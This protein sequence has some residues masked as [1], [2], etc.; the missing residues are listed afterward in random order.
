MHGARHGSL[1]LT[2]GGRVATNFA[3][4][5]SPNFGTPAAAQSH[6][7]V[8]KFQRCQATHPALGV[9]GRQRCQLSD[10]V[11]V[12]DGAPVYGE[13]VLPLLHVHVAA[14]VAV[15]IGRADVEEALNLAHL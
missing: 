6:F 4:H 2:V 9:V 5:S 12:R 11:S 3:T 15:D 13:R 1:Q 10:D 7:R 14:E 8:S